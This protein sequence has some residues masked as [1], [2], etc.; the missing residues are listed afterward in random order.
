MKGNFDDFCIMKAVVL[1][2]ILV[3]AIM[4]C[5]FFSV[6]NEDIHQPKQHTTH[7]VMIGKQQSKDSL[8]NQQLAIRMDSVIS[9][10]NDITQKY[11]Q[12]IDTAINK[13][14]IWMGFWMTILTFILM[15][16]GFW[17]YLKVKDDRDKQRELFLKIK[18]QND[19]MLETQDKYNALSEAEN[20]I[21]IT[22]RTIGAIND[23]V[24]LTSI[25][26]RKA[27]I[28]HYLGNVAIHLEEYSDCMND[29][30]FKN[31]NSLEIIQQTILN[32]Q[33]CLCR[34][35][36][37]FSSPQSNIKILKALDYLRVK[38]MDLRIANKVKAE[39]VNM[40]SQL[41]RSLLEVI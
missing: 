11:P 20:Q 12:E 19:K 24:M 13:T 14:N 38:E 4:A 10:I 16:C 8:L 9:I 35:Q 40:L 25:D 36:P 15:I 23:P 37:L 26:K 1:I 6:A 28:K 21:S 29:V 27:S 7:V 34:I 41:I 39:D 33:L 31:N 32:L 17:Q 30:K 2:V 18:E 22:L 5:L 3:L